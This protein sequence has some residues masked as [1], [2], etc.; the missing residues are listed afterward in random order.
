MDLSTYAKDL[1][2]DFL[3]LVFPSEC[4]ACHDTLIKNEEYIC[5]SCRLQLPY[6]SDDD[7]FAFMN[8]FV[9]FQSVDKVNVF[10]KYTK[11]GMVQR[12]IHAIKYKGNKQLAIHLGGIFGSNLDNMNY[13]FILPVPLTPTKERSRG[14]N[15]SYFIAKGISSSISIPFRTDLLNRISG[16]HSQTKKS[17]VRRWLETK[18]HFRVSSP[19]ELKD[20]SILLVDDV[21]TTGATLGSICGSLERCNVGRIGILTLAAAS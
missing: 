19:F 14:Y 10:L 1:S 6:I 21:L 13:D 17:K 8:R 15:Q 16:Q 7:Q 18:D 12:I 3:S 9:D 2:Q 5:T 11:K 4:P 20:K